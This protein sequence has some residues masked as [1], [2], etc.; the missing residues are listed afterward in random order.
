MCLLWFVTIWPLEVSFY[1]TQY[2]DKQEVPLVWR[3]FG[4][5]NKPGGRLEE[6][7]RGSWRPG[8]P[9]S[10]PESS[11]SS[12]QRRKHIIPYTPW[13]LNNKDGRKYSGAQLKKKFPKSCLPKTE[14]MPVSKELPSTRGTEAG[15][16]KPSGGEAEELRSQPSMNKLRGK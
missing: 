1:F 15:T 3:K 4:N 7:G 5:E 6:T 16:E 9:S 8:K 12:P 14:N 10:M 2:T 13:L 11:P